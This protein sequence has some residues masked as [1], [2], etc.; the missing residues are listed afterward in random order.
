MTFFGVRDAWSDTANGKLKLA[1]C[2]DVPASK[3]VW[4]LGEYLCNV[5]HPAAGELRRNDGRS[6]VRRRWWRGRANG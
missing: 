1:R 2:K 3:T 6:V 4:S 5:R